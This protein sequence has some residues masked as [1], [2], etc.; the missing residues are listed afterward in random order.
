[1]N[2][3]GIAPK[4]KGMSTLTVVL[5]VAGILLVL[6]LGTCTAGA[7]WVGHKA[8]EVKENIADGGLVLASP[9]EVTAELE[10]PKKD[11]VGAWTS[12]SGRS[13]LD[14]KADGS[15]A[16]VQNEHGATEKLTAPIAAFAGNDIE[17]RVGLTFK[18]DVSVPPHRVGD[19]FEMTARGIAFHRR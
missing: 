9:P 8:K 15:L 17:L 16:L 7:I 11:Y 18:I 3:P 13:Q 1:M 14:I 2:D 5:I 6:A 10:G 4:K 19:R 12:A